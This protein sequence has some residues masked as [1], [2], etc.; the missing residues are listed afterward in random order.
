MSSLSHHPRSS[1][2]PATLWLLLLLIAASACVS[3]QPTTPT[4]SATPTATVI[5]SPSPNVAETDAHC[6]IDSSQ[7]DLVERLPRLYLD[8]KCQL[9]FLPAADPAWTEVTLTYPLGWRVSLAN[10]QGTALLFE[11]AGRVFFIQF[12]PSDLPL[13]RADEVSAV[14]DDFV[15]PAVRA[16]EV[17]KEKLLTDIGGRP[18]LLL[19]TT[20]SEQSIRRYFLRGETGGKMPIIVMLQVTV[21]APNL[22][23]T[24]LLPILEEMI[25][26]LQFGSNP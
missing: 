11:L 22:D 17:V 14:L 12:Y 10:P 26:T 2:R 23:N 9:R 4:L 18:V 7:T 3:A 6:P 1:P 20:L 5:A 25:R 8:G 24:I 16:E 15:D 21:A 13:E 19:S